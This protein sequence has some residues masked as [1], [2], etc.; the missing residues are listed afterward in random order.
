MRH[1]SVTVSGFWSG[2][3]IPRAKFKSQFCWLVVGQRSSFES[4]S[5]NSHWLLELL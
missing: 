2:G 5:C 3:G 4:L 1:S